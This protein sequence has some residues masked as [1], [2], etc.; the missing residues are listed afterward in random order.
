MRAFCRAVRC[1][2]CLTEHPLHV[3]VL[4]Q[5][6]QTTDVLMIG[7]VQWSSLVQPAQHLALDAGA[8]L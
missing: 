7:Q 6:A 8:D 1:S 4:L 5:N 3:A 2:V